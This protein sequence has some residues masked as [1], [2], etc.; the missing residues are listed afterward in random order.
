MNRDDYCIVKITHGSGLVT[1]RVGY[2]DKYFRYTVSK[3][4]DP[5]LDML[6]DF[7]SEKDAREYLE[8][9]YWDRYNKSIIK[10]ERVP[11]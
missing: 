2:S 8:S 10:Q 3:Y 7:P 1:Y 9:Y 11:F 4:M 6:A 5:D